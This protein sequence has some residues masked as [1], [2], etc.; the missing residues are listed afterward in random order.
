V[1]RSPSIYPDDPE[2]SHYD[3]NVYADL[4][5][6]GHAAPSGP[7]DSNSDLNHVDPGAGH[8]PGAVPDAPV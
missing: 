3:P 5:H 4:G 8:A 1:A 6:S 2:S 7:P